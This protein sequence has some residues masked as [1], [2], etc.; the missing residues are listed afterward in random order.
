VRSSISPP[1]SIATLDVSRFAREPLA[2]LLLHEASSSQARV[3]VQCVVQAMRR[4]IAQK[5]PRRMLADFLGEKW[6]DSCSERKS[7]WVQPE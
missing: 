4:K 2:G 3:T 7:Q 6:I 5:A 1:I